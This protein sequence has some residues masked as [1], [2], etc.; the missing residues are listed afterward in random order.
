MAIAN[1]GAEAVVRFGSEW[2][3]VTQGTIV[4]GGGMA[5][6]YEPNRVSGCRRNWRGA[7]VWDIEG[8][9]RFHPRGEIVH[10]S[11]M[12]KHLDRGIITALS[13][14]PWHLA[15]PKDTT[16]LEIWFHNFAQVGGRCDA[17]DSRYG[18]NYWFDVGGDDPIQ[19][20]DAVRYRDGASARADLVN[21]IDQIALKKNV[22]PR[23]SS[24]P[25]M[26][27][28]LRTFFTVR[29]WVLNLDFNKHVWIDVHVFQGDGGRIASGTFPLSWEGS[30]S[31]GGDLFGFDGEI[32]KGSTATPGSVSPRPDARFVQFRLYYSVLNQLF[33]DVILHQ[34]ELPEDAAT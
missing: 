32:Y 31:G 3:P 10:S 11:V 17:W 15:V 28:D 12:E 30:A 21:V 26:G 6:E 19:L 14:T 24:G 22:F 7:E 34:L 27:T 2:P 9:V 20:P 16:R 4:R 1:T 8:F 18:E 5:I 23:P 33:S 25:R 13:P 29:A